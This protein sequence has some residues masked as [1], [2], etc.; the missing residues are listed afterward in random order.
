MLEDCWFSFLILHAQIPQSTACIII[1]SRDTGEDNGFVE[2]HLFSKFTC[3]GGG[4]W[5]SAKC[6]PMKTFG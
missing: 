6:S 5:V 1:A 3:V 2:L 4:E